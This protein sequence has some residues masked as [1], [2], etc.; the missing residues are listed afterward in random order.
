ML[1]FEN[2]CGVAVP[3]QGFE[4]SLKKH[5]VTNL[6][7][8]MSVPLLRSSTKGIGFLIAHRASK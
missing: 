8:I 1:G 3:P 4:S 6:R 5:S 2:G 7:R